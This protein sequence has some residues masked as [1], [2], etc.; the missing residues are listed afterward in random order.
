ME[1]M[2]R[3]GAIRAYFGSE[4]YPTVTT[5]E[6]KALTGEERQEL[7]EGAAKMLGVEL[8]VTTV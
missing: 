3:I 2:N 8:E 6:L 1:K 4:G 5:A 7:A